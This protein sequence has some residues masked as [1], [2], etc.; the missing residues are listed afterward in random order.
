MLKIC[1]VYSFFWAISQSDFLPPNWFPK[2]T[3]CD[4]TAQDNSHSLQINLLWIGW[5][6]SHHNNS[7]FNHLITITYLNVHKIC[8][9]LKPVILMQQID[10]IINKSTLKNLNSGRIFLKSGKKKENIIE[11]R[12]YGRKRVSGK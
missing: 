2:F 9:L 11:I 1:Y 7:V 3:T 8:F 10:S 12:E 5:H 4:N 6:L